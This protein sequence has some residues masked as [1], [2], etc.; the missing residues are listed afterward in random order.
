MSRV[1]AVDAVVTSVGGKVGASATAATATS[2][3]EVNVNGC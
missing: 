3:G 1:D 2:K